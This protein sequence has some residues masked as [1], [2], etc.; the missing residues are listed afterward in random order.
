V[1]GGTG[2]NVLYGGGYYSAS[3]SFG[4]FYFNAYYDASGTFGNLGSRLLYQP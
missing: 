2:V 4:M 1:N 3:G